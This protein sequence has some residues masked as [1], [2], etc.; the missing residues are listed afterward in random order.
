MVLPNDGRQD[1]SGSSKTPQHCLVVLEHLLLLRLR[2]GVRLVPPQLP[3]GVPGE[4]RQCELRVVPQVEPALVLAAVRVGQR[5][6]DIVVAPSLL[7][8][9]IGAADRRCPRAIL[10][11]HEHEEVPEEVPMGTYP[12]VPY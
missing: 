4:R 6:Q 1:D 2:G 5:G 8:P 3:D 9:E 12:Q 11:A 7:H 10:Q